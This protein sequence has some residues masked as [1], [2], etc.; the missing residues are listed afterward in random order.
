VH[1][2]TLTNLSHVRLNVK[3]YRPDKSAASFAEDVVRGLS[4]A[5]KTLLP[6]YFYD[7]A[8]AKL[9]EEI[10]E[11]PEYY[12]TRAEYAI[13][14]SQANEIA[15]CF[16]EPITLVELGSGN[17]SKTRVLLNA[18]LQRF[19]TLHYLPIDLSRHI[20]IA[21]AKSLI[22]DYRGLKI[23]AHV[24]DYHTA[25]EILKNQP[26]EIKLILFL[27]SNI[28][29]LDPEEAEIFLR[30]TRATMS[31]VDRVLVGI[32][33]IKDKRILEPAY[34]DAQKVTARFNLNMLVR[35]NRELGGNFD[36][37][38]F[39]HRA[40]L[41]EELSRV[42]MHLVSTAQQTVTLRKINRR[43]VFAKGET[44]HTENS[45]K[46]SL[47]QI[48]ELAS[49]SGFA[50]EKSWLDARKWFSVNLLAPIIE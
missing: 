22:E 40:F 41:N 38:K 31:E 7:Q 46:F 32:D 10:C 6:K 19:E 24:S 20:L 34:D 9:F 25:L 15:S 36:V 48:N 43:F 14:K 29:N 13:L 37:A 45:Y 49:R 3:I 5:P 35:I 47:P 4:A 42:E 12:L 33:L 44:I 1:L 28:G 8:G 26:G 23:T 2:D 16:D 11:L 50:V 39:R 30:K 18:F 17:S 21:T 27:G